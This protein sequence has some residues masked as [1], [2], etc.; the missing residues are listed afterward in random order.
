MN[1]NVSLT[2]LTTVA[3]IHEMPYFMYIHMS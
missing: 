3:K 2:F 1:E